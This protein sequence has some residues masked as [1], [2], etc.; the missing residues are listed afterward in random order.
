M[1][2]LSRAGLPRSAST[3]TF[4]ARTLFDAPKRPLSTVEPVIYAPCT[5]CSVTRHTAREHPTEAKVHYP[6]HPQFGEAVIVRRRLVTHNVEMAVILQPD[7]SLA[8]LP[9]WMLA[10]SAALH[11]VCRSPT[12]SIAFLRSLRVEVDA[13]LASLPSDSEMGDERHAAKFQNTRKKAT[14]AVRANRAR[15]RGDTGPAT[16]ADDADRSPAERDRLGARN[17]GGAQCPRSPLST[18]RAPPTS[19]FASRRPISWSTTRR[20]SADSMRSPIALGSSAGLASRSSMMTLA[21]REAA[22]PAPALIV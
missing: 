13:L 12:I 18:A 17:R 3:R 21:A 8:C 4:S 11:R 10:E 7:G 15:N 5:S 22:S 20:A 1:L 9:A 16:T 19:T 6:Y 2:G 14:R